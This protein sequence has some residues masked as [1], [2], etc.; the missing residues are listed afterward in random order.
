MRKPS[1]EGL[2]NWL[3]VIRAASGRAETHAPCIFNRVRSTSGLDHLSGTALF[4]ILIIFAT[5][6]YHHLYF[7]KRKLTSE[8]LVDP[9]KVT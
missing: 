7:M 5:G 3:Q 8:M 2:K 1:P 6:G 9:F 4:N